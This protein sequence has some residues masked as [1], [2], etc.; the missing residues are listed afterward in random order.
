MNYT[1][2]NITEPSVEPVTLTEA[3]AHVR[4]TETHDDTFITALIVAARNHAENFCGRAFV[5]RPVEVGLDEFPEGDIELPGGKVQWVESITYR[6]EDD[7]VTTWSSSEWISGLNSEPARIQ[8]ALG[9][10][11]PAA[12]CRPE[13]VKVRYVVGYDS[14]GSPSDY[15]AN[16]PQAI[17]LAMLLLIGHWYENRE[18]VNV[19]NITTTLDFT[20]EALLMPY[21]IFRY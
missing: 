6:D 18:T 13:S 5:Q 7:T 17:K 12:R 15:Q 1:L 14:S 3:K 9:Y 21:R 20:V 8:P 2:R 16:I 10:A 4:Q 11:Y 19:G